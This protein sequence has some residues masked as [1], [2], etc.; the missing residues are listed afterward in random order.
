MLLIGLAASNSA[1]PRRSSD[2]R[3]RAESLAA[4]CPS[5]ADIDFSLQTLTKRLV[6]AGKLRVIPVSDEKK[7]FSKSE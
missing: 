6:K 4:I 1:R 2:G 7:H 5:E 3:Y